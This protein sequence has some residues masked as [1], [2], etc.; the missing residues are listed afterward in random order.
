M[1]LQQESS[2]AASAVPAAAWVATVLA[3][4]SIWLAVVVAG[5]YAPDFVSGSQHEH[6]ALVAATGWIW[7][8]VATAFVVLAVIDGFRHRATHV[9]AWWAL[10]AGTAIT[11]LI[12]AAVCVNAPVFVTGTDPTTIPLAALGFPIVGVFV[13]WFVC[14]LVKTAFDEDA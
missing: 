11:W 1:A 7:G 6:L 9:A 4:G 12:V 8:L 10:A 2:R 14:A 5:A 13:T 3:I